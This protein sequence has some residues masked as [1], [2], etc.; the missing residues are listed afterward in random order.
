MAFRVIRELYWPAAGK[1]KRQIQSH[2][3]VKKSNAWNVN[4]IL[5]I[6]YIHT[7]ADLLHTAHHDL[8]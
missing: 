3:V 8:A 1:I 4:T 5:Y 2:G 6:I 7:A